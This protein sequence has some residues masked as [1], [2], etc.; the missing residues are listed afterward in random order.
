[1]HKALAILLFAALSSCAWLLGESTNP[2]CSEA[3][4]LRIEAEYEREVMH[5][6][7]DFATCEALPAI[8]AR[9]AERMQEWALCR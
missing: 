1:M 5:A 3:A 8:E 9:H 4:Y 7:S 6:C 2:A